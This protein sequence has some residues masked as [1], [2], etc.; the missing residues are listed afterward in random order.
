MHSKKKEIHRVACGACSFRSVRL[1]S[2]CFGAKLCYSLPELCSL[3]VCGLS[4]RRVVPVQ[5]RICV[6]IFVILWFHGNEIGPGGS[7]YK[8]KKVFNISRIHALNIPHI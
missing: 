6:I 2:L 5:L 1:P 7:F 3:G 4:S 8:I